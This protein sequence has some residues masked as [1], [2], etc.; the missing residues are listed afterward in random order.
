MHRQPSPTKTR[1][2]SP[3][4]RHSTSSQRSRQSSTSCDWNCGVTSLKTRARPRPRLPPPTYW[5]D[6]GT[7]SPKRSKW[8]VGSDE[9]GGV[10]VTKT[11]NSNARWSAS[12]KRSIGSRPSSTLWMPLAPRLPPRT[13][14]S[15]ARFRRAIASVTALLYTIATNGVSSRLESRVRAALSRKTV[16][17]IVVYVP[18][19]GR[20]PYPSSDLCRHVGLPARYRC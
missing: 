4:R 6:W 15:V 9:T 8:S 11:R 12:R 19:W 20:Q 2:R 18:Q 7:P 3:S 1:P 13:R 10:C 16:D 5:T 17:A 14:S